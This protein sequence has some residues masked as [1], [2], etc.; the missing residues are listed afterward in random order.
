MHT[1]VSLVASSSHT[2]K[3]FFSPRP[4]TL[5]HACETTL[6][7][8]VNTLNKQQSHYADFRATLFY[9]QSAKSVELGQY[10]GTNNKNSFTLFDANGSNGTPDRDLGRIIYNASRS[11]TTA[12]TVT[13]NPVHKEYGIRFT[14]QQ[15][16]GK[17]AQGLYMRAT[18]PIATVKNDMKM[19]VS[20]PN[21]QDII[22][23]FN[24]TLK[25]I[26]KGTTDA[27]IPLSN[28][29]I[30]GSLSK[31]DIADFDLLLGYHFIDT[32]QHRIGINAGITVPTGN[33]PTGSKVFE[34]VVGNGG[35]ICLGGG[36]DYMEQVWHN[37]DA[38]LNVTLA[39][40]YRYACAGI[41]KRTFGL[42]N[43]PL[44][45]YVVTTSAHH[46][47][48]VVITPGANLL[49]LNATITPG[50]MLDG[51]LGLRYNSG[52]FTADLGY[53]FMYKERGSVELKDS[54]IDGLYSVIGDL[55]LDFGSTADRLS[56]SVLLPITKSLIDTHTVRAQAKT[57]SMYTEIGYNFS[58]TTYPVC[59]GIGAHYEFATN[60][61]ALQTWGF[62]VK[63]GISF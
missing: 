20:G 16:L 47:T 14:Y 29:R 57:H 43:I 37:D 35:H 60:N 28:A 12:N 50:S 52:N 39:L 41:E 25:P 3:T 59:M 38:S 55:D 22:N 15:D 19:V 11:R 7:E 31:T 9:T 10:F 21:K 5:N 58:G 44:G 48:N 33:I 17:Y 63:T 1:T 6:F 23:Y 27:R 49:T 61:A 32:P 24:G 8:Q 46:L 56:S 51:V 40:N 36:F 42:N 45:D 26:S 18:L 62:N 54:V 30:K 13:F 4:I 53:N 34:A 2:N